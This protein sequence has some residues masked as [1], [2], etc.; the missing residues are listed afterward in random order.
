MKKLQL[1]YSEYEED[2]VTSKLRT[3]SSCQPLNGAFIHVFRTCVHVHPNVD[4]PLHHCGWDTL[5]RRISATRYITI[6][7][8]TFFGSK[9]YTYEGAS[10]SSVRCEAGF[11]SGLSGVLL[12]LVQH[13]VRWRV[14]TQHC[15]VA[16]NR[17][18]ELSRRETLRRKSAELGI[19]SEL[20]EALTTVDDVERHFKEC[21]TMWGLSQDRR[22]R[23]EVGSCSVGKDAPFQSET[24]L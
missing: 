24:S 16:S 17:L 2:R 14:K 21:W 1:D 18:S 9:F 12:S 7:W 10:G 23:M 5:Q 20:L 13:H 19:K 8:Q 11:C 4:L 15:V 22:G 3:T 6:V